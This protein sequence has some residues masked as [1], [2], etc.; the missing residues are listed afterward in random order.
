MC[1]ITG[2]ISP[3]FNKDHLLKMTSSLKHRGPDADGYFFDENSRIGL[4]HRRLSILDL[5]EGANQPMTSHCGRFIVV[6]NGE[7]YNYQEVLKKIDRKWRTSSDTE[8]VVEAFVEYGNDFVNHL[9]GMFA[10]AIWDKREKKI[11]L[12][13]DRI[14]IK[15]LLYYYDGDTFA[16]ASELKALLTLELPKTINL[17]A[18]KDYFFLEYIP[19]EQ[20]AFKNYYKLKPGHFLTIKEGQSPQITQYYNV[21]D[22]ITDTPNLSDKQAKETLKEKLSD[23]IQLRQ[24]S[25]VPIGSFLSGGTD[26]SLICSVFQETSKQPIETFNIG[27]DVREYDESE[28]ALKVAKHLKTKHH[29]HLVTDAKAK[30]NIDNIVDYY[31]EPFAV[32]SVIPSILLARKTKENVTVALSGDGGDELFM[33]YGYY[34]WYSRIEKLKKIGGSAGIKLISSILKQTNNKN[35]RA[36]RVMD[37]PDFNNSWLHIW[38]QEQYMFTEKEISKLFNTSYKHTTLLRDWQEIDELSIGAFEKISLF[39]IKNYLASDLLHKVDIASMAS[40]LELR[41]PFLDHNLVEYSLNL[42]R[43]MKVRDGEQKYL[44][45]KILSD[46]LPE[47]L[48]YRQKWGFPA[49]VGHWLQTDLSYLIEKYLNKQLIDQMGIFNYSFIE[50]L[51]KEFRSGSDFHFKRIWAIIVFNMWYQ[52]WA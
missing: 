21:I 2:F 37:I 20:T 3:E 49:P 27:F 45:K 30:E 44:L 4:G 22:K 23:S 51:V 11:S 43:N 42:P 47:E 31:D 10:I 29:Y 26:S 41:V 35:K 33:G 7:I 52:K 18:V 1:G 50:N 17:D 40:G 16:F 19:Q 24:I 36:S 8:A 14:G 9:N 5:S 25:D 39:D 46:Y 13:R 6:F 34:N 15:P 12:F 38:S 32:P 28:Y 48:V